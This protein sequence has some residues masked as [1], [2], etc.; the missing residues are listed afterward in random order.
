MD[1]ITVCKVSISINGTLDQACLPSIFVEINERLCKIFVGDCEVN[2]QCA[3]DEVNETNL[4]KF[5]EYRPRIGTSVNSSH[6][7][8]QLLRWNSWN[9]YI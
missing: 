1:T 4:V 9:I 3:I 8:S 7:S 2:L 6:F 5:V